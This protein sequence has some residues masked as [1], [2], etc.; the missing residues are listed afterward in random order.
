MLLRHLMP[1]AWMEYARDFKSL[2][3]TLCNLSK[4]SL[5]PDQC[6]IAK[7]N[8]LFKKGFK[9]SSVNYKPI[10]LSSVVPKTI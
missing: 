1:L 3:I 7:L 4:Q 10:S 6:K 2:G 9:S 5:F 8:P